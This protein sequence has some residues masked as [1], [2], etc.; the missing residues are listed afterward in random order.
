V[1]ISSDKTAYIFDKGRL[2]S[3]KKHVSL[4]QKEGDK[5]LYI[6]NGIFHLQVGGRDMILNPVFDLHWF[7]NFAFTKSYALLAQ[8]SHL[9]VYGLDGKYEFSV[10]FQGVYKNILGIDALNANVIVIFFKNCIVKYDLNKKKTVKEVW[11]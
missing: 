7:I 2:K 4:M 9:L 8:R 5:I 10:N 11:L 3:F 1:L 6:S